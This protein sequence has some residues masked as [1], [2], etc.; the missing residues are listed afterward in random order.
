MKSNINRFS[1]VALALLATGLPPLEAVAQSLS[2]MR[3][4]I[5]SFTDDFAVRVMP[6]NPYDR[7]IRIDVKVYDAD[8]GPIEA[9]VH[10]AS[11]MLA[12]QASRPVNV[13]IP[14]EGR[15]SR[16]VR[17]CVE[18]IPFAGTSTS[19][20]KAQICGRFIGKRRR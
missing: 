3:G 19:N 13:I 14:F 4:T 8:F 15:D 12:G 17:V 2:P 7:R 1:S 10:P 5:T 9:R 11:F 6:A 18:S 16:R 20:I